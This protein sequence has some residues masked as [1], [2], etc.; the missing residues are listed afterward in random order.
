MSDA[1][2]RA[3]VEQLNEEVFDAVEL[4]DD[5]G[6]SE[7]HHYLANVKQSSGVALPELRKAMMR[8]VRTLTQQGQLP[9]HPDAA[10]FMRQVCGECTGKG[11]DGGLA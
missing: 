8:E 5:E 10:I 11:R 9:L 6:C 7:M 2:E 3:Y 4:I 1:L